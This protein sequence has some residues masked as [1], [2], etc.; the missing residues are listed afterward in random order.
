MPC[1]KCGA[2]HGDGSADML[3]GLLLFCLG[4]HWCN[5]EQPNRIQECLKV[6]LSSPSGSLLK[7]RV[8]VGNKN[9]T[10]FLVDLDP[11]GIQTLS[12]T[13]SLSRTLR[14]CSLSCDCLSLSLS[15]KTECTECEGTPNQTTHQ[16]ELDASGNCDQ[17]GLYQ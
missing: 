12:V 13:L 9:G 6:E 8:V 1:W 2:H 5:K 15:H 16:G 10:D 4:M 3:M 14:P 11:Q 17:E 7:G